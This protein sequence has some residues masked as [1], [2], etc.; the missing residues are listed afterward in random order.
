MFTIFQ[1]V[2]N[3]C[4]SYTMLTSHVFTPYIYNYGNVQEAPIV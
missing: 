2:T 3:V 1:L 4:D